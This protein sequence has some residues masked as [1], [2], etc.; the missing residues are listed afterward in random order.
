MYFYN[1]IKELSKEELI[2]FVD[3]DGVITDYDF[4]SIIDFK[5]KRPISTN[6]KT[7]R[8]ISE[9]KNVTL[10]ILSICRKNKEIDDKNNWLDKHAP[11]F[12]K[13]HRLIISKE[14]H[15]N[16]NSKE[17]KCAY[18]KKYKDKNKK[19]IVIDD[20]NEILKYLK[21]NIEDIMLFQDSSIID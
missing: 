1:L 21:D 18:L 19:V 16:Q 17:L 20:D 2:I 11:Y 3:M 7:L 13:E 15:I 12:K 9:L 14:Q 10:Y 8:K 6:I 5:N 4:G